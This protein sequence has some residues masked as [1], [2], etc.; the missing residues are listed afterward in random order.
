MIMLQQ[1]TLME[2]GPLIPSIYKNFTPILSSGGRWLIYTHRVGTI[3]V[4]QGD[5]IMARNDSTSWACKQVEE[6]L[7]VHQ[8][9]RDIVPLLVTIGD[10]LA[11]TFNEGGRVYFCGNGGSAADAQH[12]AAELSG[13][14]YMDRPSLP[15]FALTTNTSQITSIANDY[16]YDEVFS[17]PLSGTLVDGDSLVAISTSGNSGSIVR[18]LETAKGKQVNT[19][20]FTGKTGGRMKSLCDYCIC[21]PTSDVARIQEGHE[22][23]AHII[24]GLVERELFME[25]E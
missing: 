14:F 8:I 2:S 6:S 16:S 21:I 13:R 15:A 19:V 4:K 17:R 11:T 5:I 18:A 24:C 22:L 1:T 9:I 20:G 12:W 3:V 10:K 7:R 23:C 25:S